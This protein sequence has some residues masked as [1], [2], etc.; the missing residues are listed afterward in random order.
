MIVSCITIFVTILIILI[1]KL[2]T[3]IQKEEEIKNAT[4]IV[5]LNENLDI[6]FNEPDV[7]V[8]TFI[9]N[10]NGTIKDD[11]LIDTTEIGEKEIKFEYKNGV[12]YVSVLLYGNLP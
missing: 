5:E 10:I 8:S 7:H 6:S 4:I 1:I 12:F 11:F 9:K 3:K 2:F